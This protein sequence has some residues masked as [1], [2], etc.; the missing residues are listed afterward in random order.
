METT[1]FKD[2]HAT[3]LL[4]WH[5][6]ENYSVKLTIVDTPGWFHDL[7]AKSQ[8]FP[9]RYVQCIGK[10]QEIKSIWNLYP[11]LSS[12][13]LNVQN[14]PYLSQNIQKYQT[15]QRNLHTVTSGS[16]H[17]KAETLRNL[18]TEI[19]FALADARK[20]N[21]ISIIISRTLIEFYRNFP[22]FTDSG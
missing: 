8:A 2:W 9:L 19:S 21:A 1:K 3:K 16:M 14:Q 15:N 7:K 17:L 10:F 20:S 5:F 11:A 12:L 13:R 22:S 6:N 18:K 4:L